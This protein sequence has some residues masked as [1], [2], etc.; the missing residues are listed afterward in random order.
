M[1]Q[2]SL[3]QIKQ[4]EIQTEQKTKFSHL[5]KFYLIPG[6]RVP[7]FEAIEYEIGKINNCRNNI[8]SIHCLFRY[9]LFLVNPI[10]LR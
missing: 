4:D 6:W 10:Y 5:I 2:V 9:V 7:E 8:D 1:T 3:E